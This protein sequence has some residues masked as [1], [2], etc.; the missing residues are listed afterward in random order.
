M[1]QQG[2]ITIT[3]FVGANP[4]GF[5]REG[6]TGGCSFRVG[7]TRSYFHAASGEWK[8]QPTTWLTVK[9]F[10]TLA[11][12]V[13]ASVRKGDPVI[14]SGLLNTEEWQQDGGNRSRI[15][16]EASAVGH[17]LSRGVDSFQRQ[18][19]QRGQPLERSSGQ[20]AE[21]PSG[22]LSGQSA[23]SAGSTGQSAEPSALSAGPP[24]NQQGD[25]QN[26]GQEYD[27][28][29]AEAGEPR[30]AEEFAGPEF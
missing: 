2:I 23:E 22:Q 16:I 6:K 20:S 26:S 15:V 24:A 3:G 29:N 19:A 4:I 11:V 12:N 9:A 27:G 13:L 17:D 5:G 14:V 21:T 10:R 18:N 30:N 28:E 8:D 7:S 25:G 1:A